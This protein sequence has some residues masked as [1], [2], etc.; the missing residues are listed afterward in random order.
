LKLWNSL[1]VS[2]YMYNHFPRLDGSAGK[3]ASVFLQAKCRPR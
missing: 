3:I 2:L 1:Y